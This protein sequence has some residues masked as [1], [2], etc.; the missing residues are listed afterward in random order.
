[1]LVN[2]NRAGMDPGEDSRWL[3]DITTVLKLHSFSFAGTFLRELQLV[4]NEMSSS[5]SVGTRT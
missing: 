5:C 1:M 2:K 3:P 4:P